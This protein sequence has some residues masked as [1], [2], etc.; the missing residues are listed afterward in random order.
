MNL[1]LSVEDI[2]RNAHRSNT[3]LHVLKANI[4]FVKYLNDSAFANFVT[5]STALCST[6][7]IILHFGPILT[8]QSNFQA[9]N[10]PQGLWRIFKFGA[11]REMQHSKRSQTIYST[12]KTLE[13]LAIFQI[14][15]DI[16]RKKFNRC[17]QSSYSSSFQMNLQELIPA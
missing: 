16:A 12:W 4:N 7:E 3:V 11:A 15:Q 13:I 8:G 6:V 1:N 10:F 14:Q 9:F 2:D 5:V 17:W